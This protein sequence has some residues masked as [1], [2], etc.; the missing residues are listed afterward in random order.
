[1]KQVFFLFF[2][3]MAFT[4]CKKTSPNNHEG[5]IDTVAHD[6]ADTTNIQ[7]GVN[8]DTSGHLVA[9]KM[10]LYFPA[11]ANSANKYPVV[12]MMH[13]GSYLNGD[14]ADETSY[15][16]ILAD[17][18]FIVASINYRL[19]WRAGTG[20]CNGDTASE[21]TAGY[22]AL[23]D[24]N[25]ALRYLVYYAKQYGID[26]AWIFTGGE[27]AGSS[28][29]LN[30]SYISNFTASFFAQS[31]YQTLGPINTADNSLTNTF[32]L[33]G[34][35]NMWGALPD[36]NLINAFNALPTISFHGTDDNVVPYDI[37]HDNSCPNYVMLYGSAC[38]QR[39][40]EFYNTPAIANFV[41]GGGHGPAVYTPQFLMGNTACFFHR[42]IGKTHIT[43]AVYTTLVSSCN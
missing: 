15:C 26:T 10:D 13:G 22:R 41:I 37:G 24:A 36:S 4:G 40:L 16:N 33:K 38:I 30:T 21:L 31:D 18:G 42:V 25:A 20:N 29:A 5:N 27:S 9:L 1:M 32:T 19:G 28:L 17:S 8:T 34:I 23:Q 14:K 12:M 11:G 43:S 2:L 7:Y 3:W 39:R 35:C 6:L